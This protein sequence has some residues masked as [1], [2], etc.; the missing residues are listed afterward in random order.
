MGVLFL[1]EPFQCLK[2]EFLQALD[3]LLIVILKIVL[4]GAVTCIT[5][6]R[7]QG[8]IYI[9]SASQPSVSS[10]EVCGDERNY[11]RADGRSSQEQRC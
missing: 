2:I 5:F 4:Y 3:L 6:A 9:L 7:K 1:L 8:L 11:K 10:D